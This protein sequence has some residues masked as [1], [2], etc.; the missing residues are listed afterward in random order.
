[1]LESY[2]VSIIILINLENVILAAYFILWWLL[3]S[4]WESLHSL[5]LTWT[6]G[7]VH[8]GVLVSVG[9]FSFFNPKLLI[10]IHKIWRWFL[11]EY[12]CLTLKT[13]IIELLI[14]LMLSDFTLFNYIRNSFINFFN[15]LRGIDFI[16]CIKSTLNQLWTFI[17]KELSSGTMQWTL[18]LKMIL[19]N[20]STC[21]LA[22]FYLRHRY[23]SI[24]IRHTCLNVNIRNSANLF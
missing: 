18:I 10:L 16:C 24:I 13:K 11:S 23:I 1:M 7:H 22:V 6:I 19:R 9:S 14:V 20:I 17:D 12:L 8:A 3:A 15:V 21:S 5:E 2:V 4:A